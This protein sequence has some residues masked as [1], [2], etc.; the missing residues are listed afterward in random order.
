LRRG[1]RGEGAAEHAYRRPSRV[2]R[3]DEALKLRAEGMSLGNVAKTL[4]LPMSTVI[5]YCSE[6]HPKA[7]ANRGANTTLYLPSI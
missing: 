1:D 4:I 7:A 6:I 3:R 2:F 5:D